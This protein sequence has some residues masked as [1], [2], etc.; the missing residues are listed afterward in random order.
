LSLS[1]EQTITT[2]FYP[3]QSTAGEFK[4]HMHPARKI[5]QVVMCEGAPFIVAEEPVEQNAPTEGFIF[6]AIVQGQAV[7]VSARYENPVTYLGSYEGKDCPL[8]LYG[9]REAVNF[10]M[11]RAL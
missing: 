1:S 8:S 10:G 11:G 3:L 9:V 4:L 2:K 5:V 7:T 6:T